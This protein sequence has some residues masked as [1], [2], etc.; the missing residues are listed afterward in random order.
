MT[1]GSMEKISE[2][3][4]QQY[5]TDQ[6]V[7]LGLTVL[8]MFRTGGL[9]RKEKGGE[10]P[11]SLQM[12][13]EGGTA[14]PPAFVK[15]L[16]KRGEEGETLLV[17]ETLRGIGSS[18]PS[19]AVDHYK[20]AIALGSSSGMCCLA[21][22]Y[23]EHTKST[24]HWTIAIELLH[25]SARLGNPQAMYW[26]G[27]LYET[28]QTIFKI[29]VL[30]KDHQQALY[31]LKQAA[32]NDHPDAQRQ[33]EQMIDEDVDVCQYFLEDF[34]RIVT[35]LPQLSQRQQK[36]TRQLSDLE[37]DIWYLPGQTGAQEAYQEFRT[38]REDGVPPTKSI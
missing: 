26:L 4:C 35:R 15:S 37:Q 23:F 3:W 17:L 11:P 12:G 7:L 19:I 16:L 20:K 24:T 14:S 10:V 1:G 31:W 28:E 32:I 21:L 22:H 25:H 18:D 36:L 8:G 29:C 9:F 27:L 5:L 30:K 6:K 2:E 34:R 33:L 38:L 13:G